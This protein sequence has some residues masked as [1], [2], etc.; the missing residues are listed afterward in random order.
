MSQTRTQAQGGSDMPSAGR[1]PVLG[2]AGTPPGLACFHLSLWAQGLASGV[3]AGTRLALIKLPP[4]LSVSSSQ[5]ASPEP[6]VALRLVSWAPPPVAWPNPA[7]ACLCPA[8]KQPLL[9][10]TQTLPPLVS[11]L[12]PQPGTAPGACPTGTPTPARCRHFLPPLEHSPAPMVPLEVPP[13]SS[14]PPP[15]SLHRQAPSTSLPAPCPLPPA[16]AGPGPHRTALS[17]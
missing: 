12:G 17:I 16:M 3:P 5:P 10:A 1:C 4:T 14:M 11:F 6:S 15:Y 7:L 8:W 2:G 13:T 9:R